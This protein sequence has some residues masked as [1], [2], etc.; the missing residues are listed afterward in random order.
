MEFSKELYSGS[1]LMRDPV[2]QVSINC[3]KD[4]HVEIFQI[5]PILKADAALKYYREEVEY[6]DY[7]VGKFLK[8]IERSLFVQ[9]VLRI[10]IRIHQQLVRWQELFDIAGTS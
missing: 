10:S 7:N 3:G 9:L 1:Y 8:T 6:M 4:G 2:S 5:I